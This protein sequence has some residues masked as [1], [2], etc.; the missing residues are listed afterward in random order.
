MYEKE[1]SAVCK[2]A[3]EAGKLILD[4]Y[5]RVDIGIE[6]KKDSS[7]VTEADR[8]ADGCI[9]ASL[10]SQFPG[11][12][13]L[14]EESADTGQ[15][16]GTEYCFIVD[17]L[18]GTKEFIKRNGEFTVNIALCRNGKIVA[19]AVFLPVTGQLYYASEGNGSFLEENGNVQRLHVSSRKENPR[20]AVSRSHR[21]DEEEKLIRELGITE[22]IEAGSS[23]K[24]CLVA[25]GDAEMYYR[26]GNTMEWDV[27]AMQIIVEEASGIMR[28]MDGSEIIYNKKEPLNRSFYA[29]N[30]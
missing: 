10:R 25:K 7:P 24:G 14:T 17:P 13:F 5:N 16:L 11:I 19:G 1:L 8:L 26:Y 4:I 20:L 18:D 22:V 15:R 29:K 6:Y 3:R 12:P 28:H 21:T 23:L 27:A 2:T 9:I 30:A